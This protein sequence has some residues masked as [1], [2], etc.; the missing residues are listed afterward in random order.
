MLFLQLCSLCDFQQ[1]REGSGDLTA[2]FQA[3][4]KISVLI[5]GRLTPPKPL[6]LSCS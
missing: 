1:L 3:L 4:F 5:F 2:E 6:A